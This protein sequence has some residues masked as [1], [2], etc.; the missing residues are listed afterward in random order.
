MT[1]EGKKRTGDSGSEGEGKPEKVLRG[2]R[3]RKKGNVS[4]LLGVSTE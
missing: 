2:L 3:G 4:V 1:E